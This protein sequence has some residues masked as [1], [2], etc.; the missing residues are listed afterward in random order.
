[1]KTIKEKAKAYDDALKR[2]RALNNGEDVDVEAGT[3]TCEYIFPE[4]K[5]SENDRI[6]KDLIEWF[7]EFPDMIWRGHYKKDVLAWLEKQGEQK[8][9]DKVQPKFNVGDWITNGQLTCKVL[10]VVGKSYELHLYNDDYCHFET[11]VQSVDE[12]YHLWTIADARD[13]D[14]LATPNYIYIFNSIE[15]ETETVS[16]YC[17]MKQSDEQF[18]FGDCKIHDEILNSIPA[19]KEQHDL[20]FSKMKEAGWKWNSV[21]KEAKRIT[22]FKVGDKVHCGDETQSV[23][24]IGITND[25]YTTDSMIGPIP[26]SEEDNWTLIKNK[27]NVGDWIANGGANPCYVKSIFGDYY[28]LCSCE[29]Y[30]YSKHIIDVN[31]TYH[32]WSIADARDG[33]VLVCN[34]NKAEIGGDIE[35]LPNI[36]PTICIYQNVETDSDYIH[37][38]CSLYNGNSLVLQNRMYYNTF[39]YNIH[40]ATKEQRDLLFKTI[41][42][43]GY[44]LNSET[45][46]LKRIINKFKTGDWVVCE[47]TGLVY[48]IKNCSESLNNHK[49]GFDLTNGGYIGSDEVHLYHLWTFK[50]AKCGDVLISSLFKQPFVYNGH[51]TCDSLGAYFGLNHQGELSIGDNYD[52]RNNNWTRL[53]GVQPATEEQ[54]NMLFNKLHDSDYKW[55]SEKKELWRKIFIN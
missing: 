41:K 17:L 9:A 49:L 18:S 4:L 1:M 2:A 21:T 14:V 50:D 46:E 6:K 22:K 12:D 53:T 45:K 5:E 13:G 48:Q 36:T 47:V 26:F 51:Y 27:F 7:E 24:I 11:D 8:S 3:T 20:F 33:D 55:D 25:S 35:K 54:R 29:G 23:T 40:P 32:L 28:E 15:Q 30:E 39:V 52:N 42:E 37:S 19:T 16:F 44:E 31:Y 10:G 34:I 38:Y 43:K